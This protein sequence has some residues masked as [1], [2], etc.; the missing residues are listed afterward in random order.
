VYYKC[1]KNPKSRLGGVALTR[2]MGGQIDGRTDGRRDGR[3]DGLCLRG[4]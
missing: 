1:T 2:Y 3:T 4:V